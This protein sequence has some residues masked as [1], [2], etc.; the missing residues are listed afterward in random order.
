MAES[1]KR[2]RAKPKGKAKAK[3]K[4]KTV[5]FLTSKNR[6]ETNLANSTPIE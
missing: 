6:N 3:A 5:D 1:K 4:A 2:A